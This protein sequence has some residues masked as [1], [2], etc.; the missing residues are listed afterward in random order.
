MNLREVP[1]AA[2]SA[3]AGRPWPFLAVAG[4]AVALALVAIV[5]A[6][7]QPVEDALLDRDTEAWAATERAER[8]FGRDPITIVASGDLDLILDRAGLDR[9]SVLETCIAGRIER[10][11]GDLFP[12]CRRLSRLDPAVVFTGPATFLGRA[13]AGLGGVYRAQLRRLQELPQGPAQAAERRFLLRQLAGVVARYGLVSPPSLEDRA[14][15]DRV[16]YGAGTRREG[17]K[18]RLSY[19]FPG[20]DSAQVVVRIDRNLG[21]AREAEVIDLIERVAGHPDTAIDQVDYLVTGAPVVLGDLDGP[22]RVGIGVVTVVALLL[23]ALALFV[24]FRSAWRLLPLL[25]AAFAVVVAAGLLATVGGRLSLATLAA[26]PILVGLSVDYAVQIQARFDEALSTDGEVGRHAA[27]R[28]AARSAAI[29]GIPVLATASLATA[30]G[31][32]AM[33]LSDY[34][35]ISELGLLLGI[36][37]PVCLLLVAFIG[38]PMLGLRERRKGEATDA[39]GPSRLPTGPLRRIARSVVGTG[40]LFPGR[41]LLVASLVA[42]CGW[43]VGTQAKS[44]TAISE[45]LPSRSEVMADYREAEEATGSSG[46]VDLIVRADDVTEPAVVEWLASVRSEILTEARYLRVDEDGQPVESC[47]GAELCPG[48]SIPDFVPVASAEYDAAGVR[49]GLAEL[50]PEELGSII[51]GGLVGEDKRTVTRVPFA[52]RSPS[53]QGQQEAIEM[54]QRAVR[55]GS[56][57]GSPPDGVTAE[58]T[59]VPVVLA[60]SLDRLSGERYILLL[61]SLVAVTAVLLVTG[62]SFSRMS[63]VMLPVLIAV[64]W[65]SL[66]LATIGLPLNPLSAVLSVMVVAVSTEF[67]VILSSRYREELASGSRSVEAMRAAYGRTGMAVAASAV[68]ALAGF[69]ALGASDIP[70][71]REFGLVAVLDLAV[72]VAGVVFVLP[73]ALVLAGSRR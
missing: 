72:A 28:S 15:V 61:V 21:K 19:L 29:P 43:A 65:S 60:Q 49:A 68:T 31:F 55:P 51:P 17:P 62:R 13:V 40:L 71:V 3:L 30:A 54:I 8:D 7:V 33:A 70:V 66:L 42:A 64:G 63:S 46:E 6:P 4:I 34:P 69:A 5:R 2:A 25:L 16:V 14:F 35:L 22:V 39:D 73:A 32:L 47:R 53:V 50:P 1:G 36:G 9:L 48:P 27:A 58:V 26:A 11:R 52:L 41:V 59:G 37:L 18:P 24:V 38:Y 12:L 56:A 23:M 67:G 44:A 57:A 20:G 10:G 45:L